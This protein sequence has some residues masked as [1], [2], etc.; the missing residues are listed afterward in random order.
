[1]CK[2]GLWW[3]ISWFILFSSARP[4]TW[5]WLTKASKTVPVRS[6]LARSAPPDGLP[7]TSCAC[8][9]PTKQMDHILLGMDP[10]ADLLI[11]GLPIVNILQPT[12]TATNSFS[13]S[14]KIHWSRMVAYTTYTNG[15]VP[16]IWWFDDLGSIII[17]SW[18]ER[19]D[20]FSPVNYDVMFA[21]LLSV[22]FI[23]LPMI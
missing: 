9:H 4:A 23:S 7:T 15:W 10:C 19:Y 21:C 2:T 16:V 5:W 1:M 11:L 6:S 12:T 13:W 8:H 14:A 18:G 22:T 3:L 17:G 20:V